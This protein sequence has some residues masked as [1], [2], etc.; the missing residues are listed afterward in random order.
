MV[1]HLGPQQCDKATALNCGGIHSKYALYV[2]LSTPRA[3]GGEAVTSVTHAGQ[4]CASIS[5]ARLLSIGRQPAERDA[6][7]LSADGPEV[8]I[9]ECSKS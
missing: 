1:A 3:F 9:K 6:A 5:G 4:D 8:I 7:S 2:V